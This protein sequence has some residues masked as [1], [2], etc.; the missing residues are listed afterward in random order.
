MSSLI[1][2]IGRFDVFQLFFG[3]VRNNMIVQVYYWTGS[4]LNPADRALTA[5][6][7]QRVADVDLRTERRCI[8]LSELPEEEGKVL[9][10]LSDIIFWQILNGAES[11]SVSAE[12]AQRVF[13]SDV[14]SR[15]PAVVLQFDHR[16]LGSF[17]PVPDAVSS[18][19]NKIIRM[20]LKANMFS[21]IE[22]GAVVYVCVGPEVSASVVTN[23]MAALNR[24]L[25][26][27]PGRTL[28][29]VRGFGDASR[30]PALF[31]YMFQKAAPAVGAEAAVVQLNPVPDIAKS[32]P[33]AADRVSSVS[34]ASNTSSKPSSNGS[35]N[36]GTSLSF[37]P[38]VLQIM[39]C[40]LSAGKK[41]PDVS[42]ESDVS[43]PAVDGS[44]S[45]S[46]RSTDTADSSSARRSSVAAMKSAFENRK[47]VEV[48]PKKSSAPSK[49][50]VSFRLD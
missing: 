38:D 27:S 39:P 9:Q 32:A 1:P 8:P 17:I 36:T 28:Q 23:A 13:S 26:T 37:F 22:F 41:A 21:I 35:S 30:E 42:S 25:K 49:W 40:T 15:S 16:G 44:G 7:A 6:F 18:A 3:T 33:I 50:Q 12:I 24:R 2:V 5:E 19:D 29:Q 45:S 11:I 14:I 46:S 47:S 48:T 43:G 34:A 4:H 20:A 31:G 10:G